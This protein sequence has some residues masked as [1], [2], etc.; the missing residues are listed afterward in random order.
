MHRF[1]ITFH[2]QTR[3]KTGLQ[4]VLDTVD[5]I[6]AKRKTKLLRTFG[7]IKKMK[8]ASIDDLKASGLPQNVAQNLHQALHN[9][10]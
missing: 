10:K 9:K 2:R 3:Q 4:S 1:A 6:G 8:E 7:S 5:G